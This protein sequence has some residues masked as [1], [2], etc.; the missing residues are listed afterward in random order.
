MYP[1][2]RYSLAPNRTF[3]GHGEAIV[4]GDP[5][6]ARRAM[7]AHLGFVHAT[8]K[9]FDRGPKFR[10]A[11]ITRLPG[12]HNDNSRRTR[13]II[14]AASGRPPR[15]R[16]AYPANVPFLFHYM[17]AAALTPSTPAPANVEIS[18][19][20]PAPAHSAQYSRT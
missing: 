13:M 8:I 5:E 4:A 1:S 16:T 15:R 17:S 19:T 9:R 18:P 10:R 14:S 12:D 2:R 11:R 3:G 7:M 20:W 6:G